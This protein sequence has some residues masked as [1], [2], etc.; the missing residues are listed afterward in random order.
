MLLFY[1]L[2]YLFVVHGHDL[3]RG[4]QPTVPK[5]GSNRRAINMKNTH[6]GAR[7]ITLYCR[8][9]YATSSRRSKICSEV[10]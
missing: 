7:D 4:W 8:C 5:A 6:R 1:L 10:K 2:G 9:H 3:G